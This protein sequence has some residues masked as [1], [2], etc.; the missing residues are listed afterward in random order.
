M[1]FQENLWLLWRRSLSK[2]QR[3]VLTKNKLFVL[4]KAASVS[5][6]VGILICVRSKIMAEIGKI[7]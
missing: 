1:K 6:F 3:K 4:M 5:C 7:R 2:Q